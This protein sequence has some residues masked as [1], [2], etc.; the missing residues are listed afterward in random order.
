MSDYRR[1]ALV[2]KQ[3]YWMIARMWN[4]NFLNVVKVK[5]FKM[6]GMW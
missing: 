6:F 1:D 5:N 3:I 4:N 2:Q